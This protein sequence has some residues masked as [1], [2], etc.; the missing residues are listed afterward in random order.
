[1][2]ADKNF[3]YTS[4]IK[5]QQHPHNTHTYTPLPPISLWRG[6]LLSAESALQC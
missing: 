5:C 2:L 4:A 1:M 3:G 6:H